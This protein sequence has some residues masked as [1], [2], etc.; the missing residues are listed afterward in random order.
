MFS[1]CFQFRASMATAYASMPS[2][3][4]L[5]YLTPTPLLFA[6]LPLQVSGRPHHGFDQASHLQ[7]L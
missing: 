5:Q 1:R 4:R 6:C 7:L 2:A 3:L